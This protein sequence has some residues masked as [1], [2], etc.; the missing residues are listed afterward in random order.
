MRARLLLGVA[1]VL[2]LGATLAWPYRQDPPSSAPP[3]DELAL[4]LTLRR[5]DVTL[6]S[7]PAGEDS[8]AVGLDLA[9]LAG[10]LKPVQPAAFSISR[11]SLEDLGP[12]PELPLAFSPAK[13]TAPGVFVPRP[14]TQDDWLQKQSRPRQYKLRDGDTLEALAEHWLGSRDRAGEIFE[15]NRD[16]LKSPDLLPVGLTIT[17]PPRLSPDELEPAGEN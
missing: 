11:P 6:Q 9:D 16:S 5:Q 7:G 8:P 4:D 14:R 12:P 10:N 3:A 1:A 2:A 13:A 17:I 15:A